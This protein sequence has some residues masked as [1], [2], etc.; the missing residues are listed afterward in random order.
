MMWVDKTHFAKELPMSTIPH[1]AQQLHELLNDYA[2]TAGVQSHYLIRAAKQLPPPAFVQMLVFG[3]LDNPHADVEELALFAPAVGTSVSGSG[4]QQRFSPAAVEMLRLILAR[5]LATLVAADAPSAMLPQF[6][7]LYI[8]DSTII[9]LP[10]ALAAIW[11]GCGGRTATTGRAGLKVQ[12]C[13]ELQSGAL[14]AELQ[15]AKDHDAK[16]RP[17]AYAAG[18]LQVGDLAYFSLARFKEIAQAQAYYCSRLK[19]GTR[20]FDLE[21]NELCIIEMLNRQAEDE[22]ELAVLLGRERLPSRLIGRRVIDAQVLNQ[23]RRKLHE[24]ERKHGCKARAASYAALSWDLYVTNAPPELLSRAALF[25]VYRSRWQVELVFKRWKSEGAVDEWRTAKAERVLCEV[26]A[27]LLAM[28]VKHW[29]LLVS[30]WE[31]PG[32]SLSKAGK[33]VAKAALLLAMSVAEVSGLAQSLAELAAMLRHAP[34][35]NKRRAKPSHNQLVQAIC[36]LN[37]MPMGRGFIAPIRFTP[38]P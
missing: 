15:A 7:G 10:A 23:R 22:V 29:T 31:Q 12:V 9:E 11:P 32:R 6:N 1:L 35:V 28:V 24:W 30:C 13:L 33:L 25:V 19:S 18:S 20:L 3:W 21:G 34:T 4:L 37:L 17:T 14:S 38:A 2:I 8:R 27:K 5:S 16:H 26:Y 36:R